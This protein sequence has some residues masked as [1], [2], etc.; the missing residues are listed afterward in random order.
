[1]ELKKFMELQTAMLDKGVITCE[2]VT[3]MTQMIKSEI[4][5]EQE[6]K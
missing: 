5:A 3:V 6:P 1:M 4:K 2:D